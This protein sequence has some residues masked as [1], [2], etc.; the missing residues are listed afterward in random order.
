MAPTDSRDPSGAT[1]NERLFDWLFLD[2]NSYFASVEQQENPALRGRP[3]IVVPVESDFTC[4]I[5]ASYQAK[6]FGIRTGTQVREARLRCPGLICVNAS[7]DLYV[8]YHHRVLEEIDRHMPVEMVAS[9]DEMACRLTG[10]WRSPDNALAM[11]R[12][13][14]AGLAERIGPYLTCSIGISGNRFLAKVATDLQKPDGLV[15]LHPADLPGPLLD[16]VPRDLPGIG[17][18]LE[19]RLHRHGIRTMADLWARD[20]AALRTIWGG[21]EG[22]RFWQALRGIENPPAATIRRSLGHSH[23][24]SPEDRPAS[25]AEIVAR[26][27]LLKAADRLRRE[28]YLAG[29]MTLSARVEHG[30]SHHLDARFPITSDS[31]SLQ[32]VFVGLWSDLQR[33]TRGARLKKVGITF[34]D[35][36]PADRPRQLELFADNARPAPGRPAQSEQ[37]KRD[38]LSAAMD[39]LNSRY[40]RD[41]VTLGIMPSATGKFMGNKVAFT[42]VPDQ[43]DFNERP[44]PRGRKKPDTAV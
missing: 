24:M 43:R 34:Q 40:G 25:R 12:S 36:V 14:K 6:A 2:F 39:L 41:T 32:R 17:A 38:R 44:A 15:L 37:E 42:R 22:E 8:R 16:L 35:L 3:I 5:A 21:I 30:D 1:G 10:R 11:A 9:I 26:R 33:S 20:A 23:V 28:G 7:H 13:I 19:K 4:A 27:L 18:N 29:A 31:L